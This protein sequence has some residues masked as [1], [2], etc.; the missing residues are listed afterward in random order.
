MKRFLSLVALFLIS[1]C[2]SP[3][4]STVT[5]ILNAGAR[6]GGF[7]HDIFKKDTSSCQV[8]SINDGDTFACIDKNRRTLKVR[9]VQIDSPEIEQPFGI[10]AKQKLTSLISN[11]TVQLKVNNQND[12][13]NRVLAEVFINDTNINKFLVANGYAWAYR[14]Y[15]TDSEYITLEE[16]AKAAHLGLWSLDKPISP[17]DWRSGVRNDF[18]E[19]TINKPKANNVQSNSEAIKF[20]KCGTKRTCTQMRSCAEARYFLNQCGV[21]RLDRDG[22]GR[23]CESLC[24]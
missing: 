5:D 22:D 24:G 17:Y 23:P 20:S 15:V 13:Y 6:L 12:Q 3:L 18:Q 11:Q 1:A 16:N 4:N 21:R 10:E 14:H 19:T 8:Y 9:L 2:S 7:S